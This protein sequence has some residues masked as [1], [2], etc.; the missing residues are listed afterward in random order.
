MIMVMKGRLLP[1]LAVLEFVDGV[2]I[3]AVKLSINTAL[4]HIAGLLGANH[5]GRDDRHRGREP[6][7]QK[8]SSVGVSLFKPEPLKASGVISCSS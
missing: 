6:S 4:D 7:V 2:P 5:L 3:P 8:S 1:N